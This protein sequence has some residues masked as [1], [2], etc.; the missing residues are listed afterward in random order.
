MMLRK[1][2]NLDWRGTLFE[3]V[4]VVAGILLA[5]QL[6]EWGKER[7]RAGEVSEALARLGDEFRQNQR[8]C[9]FYLDSS[10]ER[11][12]AVGYVYAALAAGESLADPEAFSQG[13]LQA[14]VVYTPPLILGTYDEMVSTG[15]LRD[16]DDPVLKVLLSGLAA[17]LRSAA[18]TV[19]YWRVG[20][21]SLGDALRERVDFRYAEE[22]GPGVDYVFAQLAS[23][24]VLVNLFFEAV[25][26]HMDM[27]MS[28]RS[29][30]RQVDAVLAT[31]AGEA[32]GDPY[33]VRFPTEEY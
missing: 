18:E 3:A 1:L 12:R 30:C 15:L 21:S 20:I 5:F 2:Q 32:V 17:D 22:T 14:E 8:F 23:D 28:G 25:D 24:R 9:S 33:A 10:G 16:L 13:L 19:P 31:L 4:V 6:D 26:T 7:E 29:L 27:L 11:A